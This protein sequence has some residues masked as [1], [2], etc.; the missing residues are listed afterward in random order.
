MRTVNIFFGP[1][2]RAGSLVVVW[3]ATFFMIIFM[4]RWMNS[5]NRAL[6]GVQQKPVEQDSQAAAG[7]GASF[8]DRLAR[9]NGGI[10]PRTIDDVVELC[11]KVAGG[12][13]RRPSMEMISVD[14][15]GKGKE[16]GRPVVGD[17][18]SF[19]NRNARVNGDV[20]PQSLDEVVE[21]CR[22]VIVG[23]TPESSPEDRSSP[24][25]EGYERGKVAG[26]HPGC[27]RYSSESSK[28]AATLGT[29]QTPSPLSQGLVD[30]TPRLTRATRRIPPK[31]SH[32]QPPGPLRTPNITPEP[33]FPFLSPS[34]ST[35]SLGSGET[36]SGSP[37]LTYSGGT[38]STPPHTQ[39]PTEQMGLYRYCPIREAMSRR[40]VP[41]L[42]IV[43]KRPSPDVLRAQLGVIEQCTREVDEAIEACA[44]EYT[45]SVCSDGSA[46]REGIG[47]DADAEEGNETDITSVEEIT[48]D[49][50]NPVVRAAREARAREWADTE[51]KEMKLRQMKTQRRRLERERE[52]EHT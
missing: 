12:S 28:S 27:D 47:P 14:N 51:R 22:R 26:G 48:W 3:V 52:K 1:R 18:T 43:A 16:K 7:D 35:S 38:G 49:D 44:H 31:R 40:E 37:S 23:Q 8:R 6:E 25:P 42:R 21:L 36:T 2:R 5:R 10:A 30:N 39:T 20:M 32:Q 11:E 4:L 46:D 50:N 24:G 19:Q 9:V 15:Q 17:G 45:L 13:R 41:A 34:V 29:A 33:R